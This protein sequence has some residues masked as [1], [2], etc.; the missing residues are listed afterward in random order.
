MEE[1]YRVIKV[2][3]A[4]PGLEAG[5]AVPSSERQLA[6]T[7]EA[8]EQGRP[9]HQVWEPTVYANIIPKL[10]EYLRSK[11]GSEVG[12]LHDVHERVTPN[13]AVQMA[14]DVEPYKLF[15]LEDPLR[16]EHLDTFRMIRQQSSTPL[17]MGEIFTGIEEGRELISEHLIDY[18]RHDLVHVGGITAG[19]KIAHWCEPNGILTAWHGPGNISPIAHMAN[20]HVS[21]VVSNFGI[22]EYPGSWPGEV[23]EVFSGMPHYEDGYLTIGDTPGLGVEI[24]EGA[25]KRYPYFRRLRPTVRRTDDT[26]WPY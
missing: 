17:A 3:V 4:A 26:P 18:V 25:V 11:V 23:Y 22:Q 2:Q 24:N 15:F 16:P 7:Q 20:A 21:S 12:L 5:Y 19:L 1:G 14:K 9:P 8:Y 13:Q 10:F 6:A